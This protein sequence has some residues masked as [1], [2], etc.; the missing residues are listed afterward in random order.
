MGLNFRAEQQEPRHM[1]RVAN[2]MTGRAADGAP[3]EKQ[4]SDTE[5]HVH[6]LLQRCD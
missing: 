2:G 1:V 5:G 3:L 6:P 4:Y